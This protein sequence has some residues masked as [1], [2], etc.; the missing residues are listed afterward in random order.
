MYNGVVV[1]LQMLV[2]Y[3]KQ[4]PD[5]RPML[6]VLTDGETNRGLVFDQVQAIVAGLGIPVYTV[7]FDA[8]IGELA[9]LSGLVE[10]AT[11]NASEAD[12]RYKLGALLNAQM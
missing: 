4:H 8:D 2:D 7:G 3:R 12:L 6:F 5:V 11:L 9:R 10:S 1:A